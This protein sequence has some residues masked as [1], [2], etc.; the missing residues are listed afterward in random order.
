MLYRDYLLD[1]DPSVEAYIGNLCRRFKGCYGSHIIGMYELLKEYGKEELGCACALASEH[2]AYGV[3][4]LKTLL[5]NPG[6]KSLVVEMSVDGVP[7]QEDV[8]R[9]L[10][11]YE[12]FVMGGGR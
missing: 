9:V 12:N 4:Y 11:F 10:A 5:K 3:E 6:N 2:G 8:D 1:T 7:H